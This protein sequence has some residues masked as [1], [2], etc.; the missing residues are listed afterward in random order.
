MIISKNPT[1]RTTQ[2]TTQFIG[3]ICG[4]LVELLGDELKLQ[5]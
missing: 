1:I 2:K 5:A 4:M 3:K